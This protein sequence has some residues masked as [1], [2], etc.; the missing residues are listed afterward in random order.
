M[1]R[2]KF[3]HQDLIVADQRARIIELES[4][5]EILLKN[6]EQLK[7]IFNQREELHQREIADLG[8]QEGMRNSLRLKEEENE[9]HLK[10]SRQEKD[11]LSRLSEYESSENMQERYQNL[12]ETHENRIRDL[13][14]TN[15]NL[16]KM[17]IDRKLKADMIAEEK[18]KMFSQK[19]ELAK[20]VADLESKIHLLAF[21]NEKLSN[22]LYEQGDL[23]KS[24]TP[25]K[26]SDES[27]IVRPFQMQVD[28]LNTK[29]VGLEQRLE[30]LVKEHERLLTINSQFR[31]DQANLE[32][33]ILGEHLNFILEAKIMFI[34]ISQL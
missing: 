15:E 10:A 33:E 1:E 32:R 18:R 14:S 3:N 11:R 25:T 8:I 29:I 34:I 19:K 31:I 5:L 27:N 30:L 6:Y 17:L 28:A 20:S 24:L 9:S 7:E 22:A 23:A 16:N 26:I 21:E 13:I 12:I 2:E 4:K